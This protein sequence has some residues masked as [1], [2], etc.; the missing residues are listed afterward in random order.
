M[1]ST[2]GIVECRGARLLFGRTFR[3]F[4]RYILLFVW[5]CLA[6]LFLSNAL[7]ILF[8]HFFLWRPD[9]LSA[10]L[11]ATLVISGNSFLFGGICA[12]LFAGLARCR[13]WL[14]PTYWVSLTVTLLWMLTVTYPSAKD[15]PIIFGFTLLLAIIGIIIHR[16]REWLGFKPTA[17]P[18]Q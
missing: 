11:P 3:V 8:N 17:I 14:F 18:E 7:F 15:I 9:K 13:T 16:K 6:F 2:I 4:P 10:S 1:Q 5:G 12:V